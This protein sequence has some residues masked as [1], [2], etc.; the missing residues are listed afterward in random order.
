M[1]MLAGEDGEEIEIDLDNMTEEEL[2][3]IQQAN[4]E[5]YRC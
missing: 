3:Q 1:M 5:A 2:A 4:P